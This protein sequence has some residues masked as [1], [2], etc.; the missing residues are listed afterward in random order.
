MPEPAK[1]EVLK[2][3]RAASTIGALCTSREAFRRSI[4]TLRARLDM[5]DL[6]VLSI[7]R[8]WETCAALVK[9]LEEVLVAEEST[10]EE[11]EMG[12]EKVRYDAKRVVTA[13]QEVMEDK[14]G[15]EGEDESES[16]EEDDK[17]VRAPVLSA[18]VQGKCPAK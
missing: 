15:G 10:D 5:Y 18:K 2:W 3:V 11:A 6:E 14:D 7:L 17:P 9:E 4:D 16:N 13:R 8:E 12:E 1:L